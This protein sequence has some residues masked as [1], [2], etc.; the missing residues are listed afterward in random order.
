MSFKMSSYDDH[1]MVIAVALFG[2]ANARRSESG[3]SWRAIAAFVAALDL[4]E[5]GFDGVEPA[6]T[7]RPAYHP[8]TLLKRYI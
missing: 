4:D 1:K 6:A 3:A 8:S 2:T 7:G 5:L